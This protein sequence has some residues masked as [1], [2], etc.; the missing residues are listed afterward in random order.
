[1]PP[2]FWS[3]DRKRHGASGTRTDD[4]PR[5]SGSFRCARPYAERPASTTLVV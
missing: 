3:V 2:G 1:M 5:T 4:D